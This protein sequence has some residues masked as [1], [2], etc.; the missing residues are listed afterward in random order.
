[1]KVIVFDT[2]IEI[3]YVSEADW[4]DEDTY[5]D[6]DHRQMLIRIVKNM[7]FDQFWNT[8]LHELTH[9]KQFLYGLPMCENE[10][11]RDAL[12]LYSLL[13]KHLPSLEQ[14]KYT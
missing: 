14:M 1:M 2:T 13:K 11:N 10:A 3:R 12:F 9:V 8:L 5:G 7:N 4:C 6:F